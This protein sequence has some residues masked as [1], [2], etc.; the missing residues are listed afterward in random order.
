MKKF[1]ALLLSLMMTVT[2]LSACGSNPGSADKGNNPGGSAAADSG[3]DAGSDSGAGESTEPIV[4]RIGHSQGEASDWQLALLE[5][6]KAVESSTNHSIEV[7]IYPSETLGAELDNITGIQQGLCEGVLSGEA[8]SNWTP[9]ASLVSMPYAVNSLDDLI[10]IASSEEVGG[11]IESQ[12]IESAKL[13]PIGFFVRSARNLTSNKPVN[14]IEDLKG[15]KIRVPNN[16]IS[17]DL[18]NAYGADALP[19]AWSEVFTSLQNGTLDGQENPY[20]NIL[21]NNIQEVQKYLIKTEHTYSWIYVLL[22]EDVWQS[23]TSEQQ[24]AVEAAAQV[25]MDFQHDY[26]KNEVSKQ[27]EELR[28]QMTFIDIDKAPFIEITKEVLKNNLEEDIYNLYLKM[29]DMN[30]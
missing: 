20:A 8:L 16:S 5:F 15:V 27:E 13:H 19:M 21:S 23:M 3:T 26:I 29:V 12:I 30:Q 14:S 10:T 11:V 9:Y 2:L 1:L 24:A 28:A 17:V 6:E 22:G 7:E 4:L 18:W 25:M